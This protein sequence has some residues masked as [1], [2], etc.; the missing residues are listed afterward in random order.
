[1]KK[2]RLIAAGL[3]AAICLTAC[4]GQ[5]NTEETPAAQEETAAPEET[6]ET[7]DSE[8]SQAE[9]VQPEETGSEEA[10]PEDMTEETPAEET[11]P[12]GLDNFDVD[13][14]EAAAF[15]EEIKAAVSAQDLEALADLTAFPVY[16]GVTEDGVVETREDFLELGADT[17]ITPELMEAVE[18]ADTEG[19]SAS[20]AGFT[21]MTDGVKGSI[22][23]GVTTDGL[24]ITGINY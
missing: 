10:Q 6:Q 23:F 18:G 4:G 8:E 13:P 3:L 15:A 2:M 1:M 16:V 22:T 9:E 19:L 20:M 14:E 5:G 17:V 12:G 11:A 21:L 7:E 24:A